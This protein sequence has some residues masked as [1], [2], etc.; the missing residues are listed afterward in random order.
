MPVLD[1]DKIKDDF[2][3][4][5][6][7]PRVFSWPVF[8]TFLF[9]LV[10]FVFYK[11]NQYVFPWNTWQQAIGNARQ[12]CEMNREQLIVQPA[13]TWSNLGFIIVGWIFISVAKNDH[14][15]FERATVNNLLAKFPGFTYLIG[16][17]TLYMG[18]GSFLYHGTL[19]FPFQK[20]DQTGM[21]FLLVAFLSYN[22]FK[23]FPIIKFRGKSYVSN[24]FF[25]VSAVI[26]QAIFYFF[27][28]KF[29]I[30]IL[31]PSLTLL[32]FI[33]NF[34]LIHKIKNT[35]SVA[36][37][38]KAAFVTL[39]VAFSIWILDITDKLCSPTS[40]FQGHALW[41]ILCATSI[42]LCYLYYRSETFLTKEDLQVVQNDVELD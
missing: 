10:F 31:F 23:I 18:I 42:F 8:G 2:S 1:F 26:V 3:L 4:Y 20:M 37:F 21:Y 28:W 41:H 38:L 25:I 15:Y 29:P 7:R 9:A 6:H 33:T 24:K 36:G 12:F 13:N 22:F 5:N 19:T 40:I 35:I 39:L 17:S 34:I 32:F 11:F 30:N 14:K 16:F 27:L